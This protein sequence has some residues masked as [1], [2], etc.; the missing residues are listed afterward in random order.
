MLGSLPVSGF[1]SKLSCVLVVAV[2]LSLGL[3]TH[4]YAGKARDA[5]EEIVSTAVAN[6][7]DGAPRNLV[8]PPGVAVAIDDGKGRIDAGAAGFS[9][10]APTREMRPNDIQPIASNTKM[11]TMVL[12]MRL[13]ETGEIGLDENIAEIAKRGRDDGR[14]KATL[15]FYGNRVNA[16]TVR[17]LLRHTSGLG[18][19][20]E[21]PEFQSAFA[22]N[23]RRRWTLPVLARLAASAPPTL[24]ISLK[25]EV[26]RQAVQAECRALVTR[27]NKFP[28]NATKEVMALLDEYS[29]KLALSEEDCSETELYSLLVEIGA[30]VDQL[31][32]GRKDTKYEDLGGILSDLR[33]SPLEPGELWE[34]ANT[35]YLLL[36]MVLEAVTAKSIEDQMHALFS[37]L[38]MID[39]HYSPSIEETRRFGAR[40]AHGYDPPHFADSDAKNV[41]SLKAVRPL[42]RLVSNHAFRHILADGIDRIPLPDDEPADS[43]QTTSRQLS[44]RYHDVTYAYDISFLGPAGAVVSTPIDLA[45]FMRALFSGQLLSKESMGEV[46]KVLPVGEGESYGL[47][48]TRTQYRKGSLFKDS[49]AFTFWNHGGDIQGHMSDARYIEG[50]P[51]DGTVVTLIANSDLDSE[52]ERM[53]AQ[54]VRVLC[55]NG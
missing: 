5:A 25:S 44:L 2:A 50:G 27:L 21:S 16:M 51:L 35:N 45:R 48:I 24:K 20:Q 14:L 11:M 47:G 22:K 13:V 34:Y 55:D 28:K 8:A 53:F 19:L 12:I 40:F 32:E 18:D 17:R 41:S 1:A 49:P 54:I 23:Q 31:L 36:G 26:D 6:M 15:K 52:R 9:S 42:N 4:A 10:L 38:G 46:T 39:T 37:K 30:H 43:D 29:A 33:Q 3:A 7:D